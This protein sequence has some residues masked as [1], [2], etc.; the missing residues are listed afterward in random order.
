MPKFM[1]SC[2]MHNNQTLDADIIEE[3]Q[4]HFLELMKEGY[5]LMTHVNHDWTKCWLLMQAPEQH[6]IEN[7][8]PTSPLHNHMNSIIDK[9]EE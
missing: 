1:V 3:S 5:L 6:F 9:L 2:T 7:L 4:K 8:L